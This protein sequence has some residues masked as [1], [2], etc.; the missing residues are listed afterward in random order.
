MF[1]FRDTCITEGLF[2]II[3]ISEKIIS[4]NRTIVSG[5]RFYTKIRCNNFPPLVL[6]GLTD[7]FVGKISMIFNG[8]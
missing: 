7:S 5:P 1:K 4:N 2:I 8:N 3:G 6:Y